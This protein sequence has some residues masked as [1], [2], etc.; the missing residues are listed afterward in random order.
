MPG[1]IGNYK[2]PLSVPDQ[3]TKVFNSLGGKLV[4][5][6]PKNTEA[7]P[8]KPPIIAN[9]FMLNEN[10][11]EL[12]AIIQATEITAWRTAAASIVAT[13]HLYFNRRSVVGTEHIPKILGVVGCGVQVRCRNFN[14][15]FDHFRHFR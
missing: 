3:P 13:K 12:K 15:R 1:F 10:T 11:G 14:S 8:P 4:T 6:F 2:L 5:V 9:I 7:N